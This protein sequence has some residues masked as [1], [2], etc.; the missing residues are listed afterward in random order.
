MKRIGLLQL[1]VVVASGSV[2][3]RL[4]FYSSLDSRP[5]DRPVRS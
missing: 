1:L 2:H 4:T 5:S 3:G